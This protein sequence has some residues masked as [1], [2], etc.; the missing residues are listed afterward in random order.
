MVRANDAGNLFRAFPATW[1][2]SNHPI[3]C[4]PAMNRL[5]LQFTAQLHLKQ[6]SLSFNPEEYSTSR[7]ALSR[8]P[9]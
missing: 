6:Y 4:R 5:V 1:P 8:S 7:I 3:R 2:K 9:R